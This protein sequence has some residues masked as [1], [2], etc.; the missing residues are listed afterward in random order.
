MFLTY[1]FPKSLRRLA[2]FFFYIRRGLQLHREKQFDAIMT[3]GTN[4][5]GIAGVILKWITGA[6]LIAEI[7][8]APENAFRYDVPHPNRRA[9]VKRFFA[10][11]LLGFVGKNADCIKLLYPWQLRKYRSLQKKRIAVFHDFVPVHVINLEPSQEPYI[12]LAGYP[13]YT[14][15]ADVLVRAFKLI[16]AQF[17][18]YKLKLLGWYTNR[19]TLDNLA[20]D[21]PQIEILD[22]C[23]NERALEVIGACSVY[24]SA[25]RTESMGRVLLEAMAARKPIIASA[26]D[27]VPYYIKDND[28][29]LL[30]QS[31]NVEELAAKLATLLSSQ[32][33][34][35]RLARSGYEKVL[36]EY[37][38]QSYTRLFGGMLQ[39]L[40]DG[41]LGS[42]RGSDR[43][44]ETIDANGMANEVRHQ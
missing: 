8:G 30:F 37:D 16:A 33:L 3:Y 19:E 43:R 13:W 18:N 40:R 29:G 24:V 34:Q 27:G 6:Q 1:R 5:T 28:N 14:K 38:E 17:P 31:E 22:A 36:S 11:R 15:G 2:I 32:E 12:L 44:K 20:R 23:T 41:R 42:N 26:V 35:A 25:S 9:A 21:C 39:L 7:P 4:I 10:D